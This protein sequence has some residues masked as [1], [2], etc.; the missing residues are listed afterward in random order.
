MSHSVII[1]PKETGMTKGEQRG[2]RE[3]KETKER[4]DQDHCGCA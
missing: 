2:N 4:E 1:K 3:A